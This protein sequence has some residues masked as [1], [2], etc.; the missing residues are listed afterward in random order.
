V[1]YPG[2]ISDDQG[3]LAGEASRKGKTALSI[4]EHIVSDDQLTPALYPMKENAGMNS[5]PIFAA[6]SLKE[7]FT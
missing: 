4:Y 7:R 2:V 5:P 1:A 6:V 3:W